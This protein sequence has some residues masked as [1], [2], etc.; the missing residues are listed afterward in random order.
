M[1]RPKRIGS[2][3]IRKKLENSREYREELFER[4]LS[5]IREGYSIDCFS[6]LST[7]T[8][9]SLC[10]SFPCEFIKEELVRA[11]REGKIGWEKIGRRQ[12]TG[13]CLGNSRSWYY[14]MA[15]RYGWSDRVDTRVEHSGSV[16]VEVVSYA[17]NVKPLDTGSG[18]INVA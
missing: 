6:E 4:L 16:A 12:A 18:A 15:H 11:Q 1:A 2:A 9:E 5:H 8:I 13:E 17:R 7:A 10:A 14:N 3:E